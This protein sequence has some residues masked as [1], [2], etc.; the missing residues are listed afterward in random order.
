MNRFFKVC[1]VCFGIL[2]ASTAYSDTID[3]SNNTVQPSY[4]NSGVR[5]NQ[6]NT[7]YSNRSY[8]SGV[9]YNSGS[10]YAYS[11]ESGAPADQACGDVATGDCWCLYCHYEPCYYTTK[12]CVEEQIPCKKKCWRTVPQQYEVQRCRYV[13]QYYTETCCRNVKECYEVDDVKCCKKWVCQ[14]NVK[15]VP[16][17]Y[18]K[19]TCAT[20]AAAPCAPACDSGCPR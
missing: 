12:H 19:Q 5:G 7:Q 4:P 6:G 18:W 14:Q 15:Y 3:A 1:A 17:Y 11:S 13:P 9:N 2:F 10:G 20:P 16:R 8:N